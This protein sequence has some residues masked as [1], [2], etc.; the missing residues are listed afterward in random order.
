MDL[1]P[2]PIEEDLISRASPLLHLQT[3]LFRA[4][5]G[6]ASPRE[7][8]SVSETPLTFSSQRE[9][10]GHNPVG[11]VSAAWVVGGRWALIQMD[12]DMGVTMEHNWL[13][14]AG[15]ASTRVPPA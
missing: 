3:L 7:N 13:G 1:G 12:L 14:G 15:V 11:T 10:S 8:T 2:T 5:G 9:M 6:R 4:Y